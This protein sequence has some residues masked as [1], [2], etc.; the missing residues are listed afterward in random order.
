MNYNYIQD[1]YSIKNLKDFP[2]SYYSKIKVINQW[3]NNFQSSENTTLILSGSYGCG[4]TTLIDL[5]LKKNDYQKFYINSTDI[6]DKKIMNNILEITEYQATS[7]DIFKMNS[8]IAVV[9]EEVEIISLTSEK[10][11]IIN[12]HNQNE[13]N[14]L[15]PLILI[16]SNQHS[17][18]IVDLKKNNFYHNLYYPD[19]TYYQLFIKNIMINEKIKY[20]KE[21]INLI[22]ENSQKDFR[23]IFHIISDLKLIE[24]KITPQIY[25][26]YFDSTKSKDKNIGLFESTDILLNQYSG[27]NNIIKYYSFEKVLLPLMIFENYPSFFNNNLTINE[28]LD[29]AKNISDYL[30]LGDIIETSIYT[31]QNWYLQD[32][33]GFYTCVIPS[34]ELNNNTYNADFKPPLKFSSDLNRTSLKNINRKNIQNIKNFIPNKSIDEILII[35]NIINQMIEEN[36]IDEIKNLFQDYKIDINIKDIEL[37]CKIDKTNKL[38]KLKITNKDTRKKLNNL[39]K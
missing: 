31:D 33:H 36:K 30:S 3:L 5:L 37:I 19:D 25:S 11:F 18:M 22:L 23:K 21:I 27:V 4:K 6:K 12:L 13:K 10:N 35:S 32:I 2:S 14:H 38:A 15:F 24:E 8:K 7:G 34:Y 1:K 28:Y 9:I 29:K 39:F 16:T 20:S 26:K 17:K